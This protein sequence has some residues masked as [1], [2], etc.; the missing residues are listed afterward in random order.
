MPNVVPFRKGD[1][2]FDPE[3][4]RT[5]ASGIRIAINDKGECVARLTGYMHPHLSSKAHDENLPRD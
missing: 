1:R 4:A 3:R 5:Q 2:F